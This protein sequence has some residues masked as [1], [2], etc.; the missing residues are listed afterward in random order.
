MNFGFQR[1]TDLALRVMR[2]LDTPGEKLSGA[3]LSASI[4][5]TT[6]FLPQVVAPLIEK[7]WVASERGPGGGYALTEASRGVS[8][9]DVLEATEGP[10]VD[11]RCV[12]RDQSCPS[13]EACLAHAVWADA[14]EHL[15]EGL[16]K[17]PAI[18]SQGETK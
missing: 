7:G 16:Q 4:G 15:I 2:R 14:R 10:T 1:K 6:A 8:L 17:I 13:D 12:L 5:T 9:F 18:P 11:G 3:S